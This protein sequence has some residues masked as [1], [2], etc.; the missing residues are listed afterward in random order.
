MKWNPCHNHVYPGTSVIYTRYAGA[1]VT[2]RVVGY[3][4]RGNAYCRITYERGNKPVV[5][6]FASVCYALLIHF[7]LQFLCPTVCVHGGGTA[8]TVVVWFPVGGGG[9]CPLA[10]VPQGWRGTVFPRLGKDTEGG[11]GTMVQT[12]LTHPAESLRI[13]LRRPVPL[14]VSP[15]RDYVHLL[16]QFEHSPIVL[17][18]PHLFDREENEDTPSVNRRECRSTFSNTSRTPPPPR[19]IPMDNKTDAV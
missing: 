7:W 10:T 12:A 18:D 11:K 3:S 16:K 1:P 13:M 19:T 15:I 17:D 4:K 14:S 9:C 8:C 5:Y 6:D 2:G